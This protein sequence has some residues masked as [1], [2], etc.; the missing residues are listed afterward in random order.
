[1]YEFLELTQRSLAELFVEHNAILEEQ[2][3]LWKE[4]LTKG[5]NNNNPQPLQ[6]QLQLT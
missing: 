1:M 3:A 6:A 4:Q 2:D 5:N